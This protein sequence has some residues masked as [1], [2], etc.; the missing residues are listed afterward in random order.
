MSSLSLNLGLRFTQQ[1]Y[2]VR[3]TQKNQQN[4]AELKTI[5]GLMQ[6]EE[7]RHSGE[8]SDEL[9]SEAE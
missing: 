3:M 1:G 8:I 7:D 2:L 6:P 4:P 9:T 5:A